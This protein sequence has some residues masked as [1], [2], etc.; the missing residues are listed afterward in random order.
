VTSPTP[1]QEAV[2]LRILEM[3]EALVAIQRV[4][5]G[6]ALDDAGLSRRGVEL[7]DPTTPPEVYPPR[8]YPANSIIRFRSTAQNLVVMNL[9]S[10]NVAIVR[11]YG[12]RL[13][14][15]SAPFDSVPLSAA[16][17]IPAM[18]AIEGDHAW[19]NGLF[20]PTTADWLQIIAR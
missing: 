6:P 7:R 15:W 18:S 3:L 19:C 12:P 16:V 14:Q 11:Y 13:P 9:H 4:E 1:P 2:L 10:T 8:S 17:T 5:R 20:L